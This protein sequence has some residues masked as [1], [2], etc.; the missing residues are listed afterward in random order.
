MPRRRRRRSRLRFFRNQSSLWCLMAGVFI[1]TGLTRFTLG[2]MERKF[3]EIQFLDSQIKETSFDNDSQRYLSLSRARDFAH[4]EPFFLALLVL[5]F[6]G[7]FIAIVL[8]I[9]LKSGHR[10]GSTI[11]SDEALAKMRAK[12]ANAEQGKSCGS[13]SAGR[14]AREPKTRVFSLDE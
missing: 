9:Y 8:I 4:M 2:Y 5:P 7:L 13:K 12:R 3:A 1:V 14:G 6:V 11:S 10:T